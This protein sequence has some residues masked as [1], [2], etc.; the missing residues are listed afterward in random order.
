METFTIF[1]QRYPTQINR[2]NYR[3]NLIEVGRIEAKDST[4]ATKIA[5]ERK[6]SRFPVLWSR[7][8]QELCDKANRQQQAQFRSRFRD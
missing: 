6:L 4:E 1:D 7:S 3:A 5:R 2:D 8:I